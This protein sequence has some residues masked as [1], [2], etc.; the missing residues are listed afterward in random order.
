MV[1]QNS[2]NFRCRKSDL[3]AVKS[4]FSPRSCFLYF[5]VPLVLFFCGCG[6]SKHVPQT[7]TI[8][9]GLDE[10]QWEQVSTSGFGDPGNTAIVAMAEYRGR[11]YALVR[12][13]AEG[14]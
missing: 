10:S 1:L 6:Q 5:L 14:V 4:T 2:F 3:P 8:V 11:L 7:L 12:N 13:D 9:D